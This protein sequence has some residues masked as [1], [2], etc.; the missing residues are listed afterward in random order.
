MRCLLE[1]KCDADLCV[2]TVWAGGISGLKL[3][4]GVGMWMWVWMVP[5]AVLLP[6]LTHGRRLEV[7]VDMDVA[8]HGRGG[9]VR[10][11]LGGQTEVDFCVELRGKEKETWCT[12]QVRKEKEDGQ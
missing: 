2:D 9:P 12:E 10:S 11:A 5:F 6:A 7:A 3:S 4:G 1:P 8:H